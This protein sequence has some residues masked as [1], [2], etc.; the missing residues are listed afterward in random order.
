MT[1]DVNR[2]VKKKFFFLSSYQRKF[3]VDNEI[4]Y[5]EVFVLLKIIK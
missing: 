5:K 1:I 4:E 2:C 3:Y